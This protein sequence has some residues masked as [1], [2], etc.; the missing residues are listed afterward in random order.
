MAEGEECRAEEEG[1][2]FDHLGDLW[3]LQREEW[4]EGEKIWR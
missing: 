1:K 2:E 4:R 3:Y